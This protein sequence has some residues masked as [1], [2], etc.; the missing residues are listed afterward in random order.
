MCLI[1]HRSHNG[2]PSQ[3]RGM[4]EILQYSVVITSKDRPAILTETIQA[5]LRQS[6]PPE[7]IFVV[8]DKPS[9]MDGLHE[10]CRAVIFA[11][12][13]TAKRN[14]GMEKVPASSSLLL[15]VDDDVE[16]HRDYALFASELFAS[17][18]EIVAASGN[19]LVDASIPRA[20]AVAILAEARIPEWKFKSHGRDSVL[21]GCNMMIRRQAALQERFD[22][23]LPLYS[24]GEDYEIS[25]RLRRRGL[26]G[27]FS[28]GLLVHLKASSGRLNRKRLAWSI[29]AN[30]WYFIRKGSTHLPGMLAYLRFIW[31]FLYIG[32]NQLL[33]D[34]SEP[35]TSFPGTSGVIMAARDL[36]A[37]RLTPSR[38]L[39]IN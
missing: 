28:T 25:I 21:Y 5:L 29:I 12:S 36:V 3:N 19:V 14:A 16:L 17:H 37:R 32:W 2:V 22:E 23:A 13:N 27:R 34:I 31:T 10:C 15:F 35:H 6:H 8:V 18:R 24:F 26:V 33:Q 38:L 9:D 11:G 39:D 20:R 7:N 4:N 30:N 1:D